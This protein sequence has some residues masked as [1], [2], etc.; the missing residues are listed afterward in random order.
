MFFSY[1]Y[2]QT[3]NRRLDRIQ[4]N[5]WPFRWPWGCGGAMW[6]ASPDEAHP[7]LQTKPLDAAIGRVLASHCRDGR[8]GRQFLLKTQNTNK[9]L[10]LAS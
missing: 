6:D 8:H 4:L 7:G 5:C 9:K 10:F 1:G 3:K 2:G